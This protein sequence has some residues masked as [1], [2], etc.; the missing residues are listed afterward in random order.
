MRKHTFYEFFAGGGMARAGLG[1]DWQCLF[2][3]DFDA[4]K[5]EAY[6]ANW[7]GKEIVCGDIHKLAITVLPGQADLAWASFPCQDLSLAGNGAGLKGER[8]G[9]FWGFWQL[10]SGL[11]AERR[12]PKILVLENVTGAL[13]SSGGKDFEE[14]CRALHALN[15]RFGALVISI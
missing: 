12:A 10:I 8:S 11:K 6:K 9:A 14:L 7:G 2:A 15:Y 5:V 1:E 4:K 3:N 13:T